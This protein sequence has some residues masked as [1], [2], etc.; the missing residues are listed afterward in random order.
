MDIQLPFDGQTIGFNTDDLCHPVSFAGRYCCKFPPPL[1]SNQIKEKIYKG[2]ETHRHLFASSRILT[3]VNDG[4]RRTPTAELLSILWD[5]LKDGDFIIA[6]GTHRQSTDDELAMIF[7]D[8]LSL[9]NK[10]LYTHDCYDKSSLI[11]IGRTKS[12]TDVLINKKAIEADLIFTINSVEPHFFA[13]FTGG[14]KSLIPGLAGFDTVQANHRL[15]KE[16]NSSALNLDSNPLHLDLEEGVELIGDKPIFTIQC[17]TDRE[18][19]IIDLFVGSLNEAFLNACSCAAECY[20]VKA[21]RKYDIVIANCE[22]PLNVNLYQLQ[23]AQE[24]GGRMVADG[25]VLITVGACREGIGS[26]YF[27]K[28]AEKYPTPELA[29]GK[30][31]DDDSFGIHKLVKTARQLKKFKVYYVTTLDEDVV[32]RVYFKSFKDI[33]IALDEA[34]SLIGSNAEIAILDDAGYTVPVIKP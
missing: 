34:V 26:E 28:L 3:I 14:R 17:V 1:E 12:G 8:K 24:H 20:T 13:G 21:P 6:T 5:Y 31:I 23:K 25:G 33:K 32:K 18:G 11:H 16:I 9:I 10:R 19:K 27:M 2:I 30:G 4:Y 7:G 29:L 22:P 15:A